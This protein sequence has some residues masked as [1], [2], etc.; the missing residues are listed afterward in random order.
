MHPIQMTL[1]NAY[2]KDGSAGTGAIAEQVHAAFE[3][4]LTEMNMTDFDEVYK[5]ERCYHISYKKSIKMFGETLTYKAAFTEIFDIIHKDCWLP[6][7]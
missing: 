4:E 3:Q 2:A 7:D 6:V 5:L 1:I